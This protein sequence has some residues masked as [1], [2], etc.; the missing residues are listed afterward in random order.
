MKKCTDESMTVGMTATMP[1]PSEFDARCFSCEVG[2]GLP[3]ANGKAHSYYVSRQDGCR[4][5]V[6][7][8]RSGDRIRINSTTEV[9][10]LEIY[11]HVVKLAIAYLPDDGVK[12][13][14]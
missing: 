6:V 11:P 9:V 3:T 2:D 1:Q 10:I 14:G 8:R 13:Q 7:E 5:L 4:M 12:S